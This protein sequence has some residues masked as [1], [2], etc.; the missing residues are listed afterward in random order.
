MAA[1]FPKVQIA[2]NNRIANFMAQTAEETGGYRWMVELGDA[3]YFAKYDGRTDLGNSQVGDGY[4]F[5]GRGLAM[6]TGRYNY[7][8]YG[9]KVGLDLINNPDLAADPTNAVAIACAYWA[10]HMLNPLADANDVTEITRRWNGGLNGLS[11]RE[12]YLAAAAAYL[13]AHPVDSPAPQSGVTAAPMQTIP[14]PSAPATSG[15]VS[16]TFPGSKEQPP[17]LDIP[18]A[19]PL[20]TMPITPPAPISKPSTIVQNAPPLLAG[21]T[22]AAILGTA[23]TNG[24]ST[25]VNFSGLIDKEWPLIV[26]GIIVPAVIWLT[27]RALA[28]FKVQSQSVLAGDITNAV[29]NGVNLAATQAESYALAHPNVDVRSAQ[30][31]AAMNYVT[32]QVPQ[33]LAAAGVTQT[34]LSN[35]VTAKLATIS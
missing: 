8:R 14:S 29:V 9:P 34:Q 33:K 30:V 2:T 19:P 15:D 24:V 11:Q 6:L 23:L 22:G 12:S 20:P 32:A 3:A 5:R 28:Y 13:T 35:L 1:Q 26:A 7:G 17:S 10:D 21:G 25:T 31:A 4:R 16:A 27:G 18:P